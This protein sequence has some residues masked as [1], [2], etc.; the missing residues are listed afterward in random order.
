M[1][2]RIWGVALTVIWLVGLARLCLTLGVK[3]ALFYWLMS[4]VFGSMV[5]LSRDEDEPELILEPLT[6]EEAAALDYCWVEFF[7]GHYVE[8]CTVGAVFQ[9]KRPVYFVGV[10]VTNA[11]MYEDDDYNVYWR[12]WA[13]KPTEEDTKAAPWKEVVEA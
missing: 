12:C 10:S 3:Y 6:L 5:L 2:K 8:P 1:K 11:P 13:D 7:P 9:G 4:V